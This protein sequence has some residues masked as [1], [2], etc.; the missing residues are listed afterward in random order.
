MKIYVGNL[1]FQ[2]ADADLN[3]LFSA[4]GTVTSAQVVTDRYTARSRGFGFVEMSNDAE[5]QAA[6]AALNG[7]DVDG[8]QLTVNEARPRAESGRPQ[9]YG[10]RRPQQGAGRPW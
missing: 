3:S 5:A 8:R 1:S 9:R 4:Y 10:D 6:I 2:T 7:K